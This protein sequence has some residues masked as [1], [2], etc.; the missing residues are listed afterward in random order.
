MGIFAE[1]EYKKTVLI[2]LGHV[3]TSMKLF[4]NFMKCIVKQNQ[5]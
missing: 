1:M 3:Q 4:L 5:W 2:E